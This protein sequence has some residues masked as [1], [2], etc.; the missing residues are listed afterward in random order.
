MV[1]AVNSLAPEQR[2]F[3]AL[4]SL[5]QDGYSGAAANGVGRRRLRPVE[6][7]LRVL[8]KTSQ[9]GKAKDAQ[10][11]FMTR[12]NLQTLPDIASG[13]LIEGVTEPD[14]PSVEFGPKRRPQGWKGQSGQTN[15]I[16][17]IQNCA[18]APSACSRGQGY[19]SSPCWVVASPNTPTKSKIMLQC[20]CT[21]R[22]HVNKL[23]VRFSCH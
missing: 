1:S 11:A 7:S 13:E 9:G 3:N 21:T 23:G 16:A 6:S 8:E 15:S 12:D 17:K 22:H 10:Y 2:Y 4:S 20:N 5:T 18:I 19:W 14:S